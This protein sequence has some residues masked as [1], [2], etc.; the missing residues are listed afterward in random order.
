[1]VCSMLLHL[2]QKKF[3]LKKGIKQM[4]EYDIVTRTLKK[5]RYQRTIKPAAQAEVAIEE[6]KPETGSAK[7]LSA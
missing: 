5:K 7:Q 3:H 4:N 1:M 2:S 6:K